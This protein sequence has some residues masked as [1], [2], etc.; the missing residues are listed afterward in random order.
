M[1]VED[2]D[3]TI[4]KDAFFDLSYDTQIA[5]RGGQYKAPFRRSRLGKQLLQMRSHHRQ[6]GDDP[7]EMIGPLIDGQAHVSAI[8]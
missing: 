4:L 7:P 8:E 1:Q 5:P 2:T 3:D 6:G